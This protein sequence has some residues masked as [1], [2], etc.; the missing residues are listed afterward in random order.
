[1]LQYS[2]HALPDALKEFAVSGLAGAIGGFI[3][4]IITENKIRLIGGSR[5]KG[6]E[7]RAHREIDL[8]SIGDFLV[9]GA[10]GIVIVF[11]IN[12]NLGVTNT[13]SVPDPSQINYLT[14]I[15]I[16]LMAGI[17][18]KKA[19]AGMS[20]TIIKKLVSEQEELREEHVKLQDQ[21]KSVDRINELIQE[22]E[23]Y[24]K[25]GE[26]EQHHPA[27]RIAK[28]ESARDMFLQATEIDHSHSVTYVC[29]GKALKRL[30]E[31]AGDMEERRNLLGAAIDATS[32]AIKLNPAYDRAYYN[33]ACYKALSGVIVSAVLKDL[34]K[35]IQI[36]PL[37]RLYARSDSDFLAIRDDSAFKSLVA[38]A[39]TA[40][41]A[42]RAA[43]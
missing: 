19:L 37:N 43:G 18:S 29:L 42:E 6:G 5:P 41:K 27:K 36:F 4:G 20:Q 39:E 22:G 38:E 21:L 1:M 34:G 23:R 15:P 31:E 2:E 35:S 12:I 30:S 24:L 28:Y 9:G 13:T 10:A 33:R 14:L 16:C 17:V 25:E 26:E 11:F 7:S 32:E 8:G 3:A 40:E